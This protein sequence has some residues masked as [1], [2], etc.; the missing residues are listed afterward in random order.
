M[1]IVL[2]VGVFVETYMINFRNTRKENYIKRMKQE[3]KRQ[4]GTRWCLNKSQTV[5]SFLMRLWI[6]F[7]K[8]TD[9]FLVVLADIIVKK[10]HVCKCCWSALP[11]C[12][13]LHFPVRSDSFLFLFTLSGSVYIFLLFSLPF[14]AP[15]PPFFL[16]WLSGSLTFCFLKTY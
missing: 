6:F 9:I 11:F 12:V 7:Q 8:C 2:Y 16:Q 1:L 15:P 14:S 10:C 4:S 13:V 5:V 3:N